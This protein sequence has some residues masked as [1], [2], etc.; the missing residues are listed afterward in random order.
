VAGRRDFDVDPLRVK[1]LLFPPDMTPRWCGAMSLLSLGIAAFSLLVSDDLSPT[2]SFNR[3]LFVIGFAGMAI[4]AALFAV[5]A[6]WLN[7]TEGSS[8]SNRKRDSARSGQG[9]RRHY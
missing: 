4:C 1:R 7:R 9:K 2:D 6:W 8:R 5:G 3:S